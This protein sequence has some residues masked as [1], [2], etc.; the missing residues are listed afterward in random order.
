MSSAQRDFQKA[1]YILS[2]PTLYVKSGI[3]P[4][5]LICCACHLGYVKYNDFKHALAAQETGVLIR[6]GKLTE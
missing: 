5:L 3:S 2:F 1:S 4:N 6:E